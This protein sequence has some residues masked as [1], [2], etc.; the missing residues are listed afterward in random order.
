[1]TVDLHHGGGKTSVAPAARFRVS[2]TV[3]K[4]HRGRRAR[5]RDGEILRT[6]LGEAVLSLRRCPSDRTEAAGLPEVI[7]WID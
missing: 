6:E 1:M 2:S 4:I 3:T 5:D 7:H